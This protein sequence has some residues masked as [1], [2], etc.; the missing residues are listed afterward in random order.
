MKQSDNR[1]D[2]L[3]F[4]VSSDL[5][6]RRTSIVNSVLHRFAV[7]GATGSFLEAHLVARLGLSGAV[8]NLVGCGISSLEVHELCARSEDVILFI[9]ESIAKDLGHDL[10]L[11]LKE[12]HNE[13]IRII[14]ILQDRSLASR[15]Q[16]FNVDAFVLATSFGSGAIARALSSISCGESYLDP[17]MSRAIQ[18]ADAPY[19]TKRER[20]V[21]HLLE[22][23][24]SNKE[25]AQDLLISP[26]TVR[27]YIQSLMRKFDAGNRTLV[28][29]NA[30]TKGL[31]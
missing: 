25:I 12:L 21:L 18:E 11:S 6:R 2:Y 9:T 5:F 23:G 29:T 28:V 13:S 26:V 16:A 17:D 8:P 22:Q 4:D 20:Q 10:V 27:D 15:I 24:M 1:E 7:V 3:R 19:L 30:R 14:Y 31:L